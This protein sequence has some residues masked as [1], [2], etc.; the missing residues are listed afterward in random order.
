MVTTTTLI[1]GLLGVFLVAMAVLFIWIGVR[2]GWPS[3]V[4]KIGVIVCTAL[5]LVF[6]AAAF[7]SYG[8]SPRSIVLTGDTVIVDRLLGD[9]T[10]PI[11]GVRNARRVSPEEFAGAIRTLNRPHREA[12]AQLH[13]VGYIGKKRYIGVEL[14]F[15]G[16]H[17][18]GT[19]IAAHVE[20]GHP[21]HA[22]AGEQ[23]AF[24]APSIGSY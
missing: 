21:L 22:P 9:I 23:S 5:L 16:K 7:F 19:P 24:E 17:D 20:L 4:V 14:V 8:L 6:V 15:A 13:S 2:T 3:H 10:I 12:D 1:L 11:A 18:N